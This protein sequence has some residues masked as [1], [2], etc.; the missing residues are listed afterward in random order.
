MET[1][2]VDALQFFHFRITVCLTVCFINYIF[3]NKNQNLIEFKF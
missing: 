1:M 2:F 3:Y